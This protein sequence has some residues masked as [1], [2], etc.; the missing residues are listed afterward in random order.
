MPH[1][2]FPSIAQYH[3]PE[4]NDLSAKALPNMAAM[5]SASNYFSVFYFSIL[6]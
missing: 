5:A 2:A 3:H 6:L 1:V 4:I